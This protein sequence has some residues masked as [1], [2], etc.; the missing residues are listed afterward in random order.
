MTVNRNV[1]VPR[2]ETELLAEAGWRF[3]NGHKAQGTKP[4]T[5]L[6]FGTGSGC[7]AIA[8]A[9][10]SAN[11]RVTALDTS[12]AALE[13]AR[14]NAERNNAV[15]KIEFFISDGFAAL[16]TSARFYLIISNPPYIPSSEIATLQPEVRDFDPPAALDGGRDGLDFYRRLA[17][18]SPRFLE[19]EGKI[20]LEF[21]DG[22]AEAVKQIFTAQSWVVEAVHED[23][24]MQPRILVAR[25]G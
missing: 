6:D 25:L 16:P 5:A 10:N 7:V 20:I 13:V 9:V 3:L 17:A 23:Y 15:D 8:L 14:Q 2:P 22:Q 21:G 24:S 18:E 1:L 11:T 12:I 19:P 4:R